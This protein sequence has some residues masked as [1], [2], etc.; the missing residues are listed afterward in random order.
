MQREMFKGAMGPPAPKTSAKSTAADVPAEEAERCDSFIL[1][2]F[3][4]FLLEN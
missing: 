4:L 2:Y 1:F 3:I